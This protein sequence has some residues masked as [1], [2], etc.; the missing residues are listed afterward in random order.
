MN[1]FKAFLSVSG[2]SIAAVKDWDPNM[3]NMD[4]DSCPW[5]LSA[6]WCL[7]KTWGKKF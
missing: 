5:L 7:S 6:S 3:V 4:F 2:N 1:E